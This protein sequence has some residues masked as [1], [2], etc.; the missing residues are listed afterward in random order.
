MIRKIKVTET[1]GKTLLKQHYEKNAYFNRI[2][3]NF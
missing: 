2:I 1:Y 3:E